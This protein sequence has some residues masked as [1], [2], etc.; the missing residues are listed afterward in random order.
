MKVLYKS[1]L[2]LIT[3]FLAA[4]QTS[5]NQVEALKSEVIKVHDR[6]MP[7]NAELLKA[8]AGLVAV[9]SRLDSMKL[10]DPEIDT[11]A[12]RSQVG[13]LTGALDR[14]DE[15]MSDWMHE[16]QTDYSGMEQQAVIDYLKAEKEK[17]AGIEQAYEES[18]GSAGSLLDSLE[19]K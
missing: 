10:A 7:R 3:V 18:I 1:A 17:I 8:K 5:T 16:F 9:L 2:L 14:A 12:V 6:I 4:C 19:G 15:A 11:A 13:S